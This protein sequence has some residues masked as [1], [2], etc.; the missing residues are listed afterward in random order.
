VLASPSLSHWILDLD[1]AIVH[2][3]EDSVSEC[4]LRLFFSS[5][6]TQVL[7]N[8]KLVQYF[9]YQSEL[10]LNVSNLL[11]TLSLES[12][13]RCFQLVVE[14]QEGTM[15]RLDRIPSLLN[16]F[17]KTINFGTKSF[18]METFSVRCDII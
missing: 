3:K 11:V 18:K 8:L 5:S 14:C 13:C 6:S 9:P 4:F 17:K 16:C 12:S 7:S 1:L 10:R 2:L 15:I